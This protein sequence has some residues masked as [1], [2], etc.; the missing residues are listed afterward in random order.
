[1]SNMFDLSNVLN[2]AQQVKEQKDQ[3]QKNNGNRRKLIYPADGTVR[4]KLLFNPKSGI[5]LRKIGRHHVQGVKVPCLELFGKECPI[6]KTLTNIKNVKGNDLWEFKR[7]ERGLSYAQYID[8]NYN[9]PPNEKPENIPTQGE[10]IIAM[11]PWSVYRD[12]QSIIAEAGANAASILATNHGKIIKITRTRGKNNR[13]EYRV[14]LD[15]FGEYQTAPTDEEYM[16]VLNELPNLND[17][18]V[19]SELTEDIMNSVKEVDRKLNEA[20]L[21]PAVLGGGNNQGVGN[22]GQFVGGTGD[23]GGNLPQWAQGQAQGMPNQFQQPGMNPQFQQPNPNQFAQNPNQF[24]Q[25]NMGQG[26]QFNQ[27]GQF[28][29]NQG[30]FNQNQ[31][32]FNPNQGQFNQ[33]QFNQNQGQ[34]NQ[35][36]NVQQPGFTQNQ[37]FSTP[38]VDN[39]QGMNPNQQMGNPTD[40]QANQGM[41]QTQT[42]QPDFSQSTPSSD[43]V[44]GQAPST[45]SNP[46]DP[47]APRA[48]GKPGCFGKHGSVD[49]NQCLICPFEVE[50]TGVTN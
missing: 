44:G 32:Q 39:Q 17:E 16:K 25:P 18:I 42:Q 6:C 4:M 50:C 1:M 36:A 35:Q 43:S 15:A 49:A 29:P 28:D 26:G 30:Q 7:K 13:V 21:S 19:P 10:T 41:N 23:Q 3:Q 20:Y 47:S 2:S 46:V 12:L 27:Q 5:A 22:L 14:E 40:Q 9:R 24:Q 38:S 31:G 11:Y 8:D 48:D 33:G 45:D 34:F 37:Q